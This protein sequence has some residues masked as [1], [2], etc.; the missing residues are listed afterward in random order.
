[1]PLGFANQC[2]FGRDGT[3]RAGGFG[4]SRLSAFAVKLKCGKV[5]NGGQVNRIAPLESF[6]RWPFGDKVMAF[7][8]SLTK[9]LDFCGLARLSEF[10]HLQEFCS[11]GNQAQ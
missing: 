5:S 9:G 7:G 2:A 4:G 3:W 8:S 11:A 10:N 1:M 6:F